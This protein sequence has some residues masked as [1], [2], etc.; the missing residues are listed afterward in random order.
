MVSGRGVFWGVW[1]LFSVG[2]AHCYDSAPLWGWCIKLRSR[3][4]VFYTG[5]KPA[6]APAVGTTY[7][8]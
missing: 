3:D 1:G 7:A 5:G 8:K 2:D 4:D 6:T